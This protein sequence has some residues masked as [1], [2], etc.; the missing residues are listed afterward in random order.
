MHSN[1]ELSS[2]RTYSSPDGTST[3]PG[4][5]AAAA[6]LSLIARRL[7]ANAASG[8]HPSLRPG[9]AREFNQ[10]RAYQPGDESRQ[11]D[12]KLYARSDRFFLR[13]GEMDSRVS[14]AIV[15]DATGSM[16]HRG[17]QGR[18]P[19]KLDCA[20]AVAAALAF[21]AENQGD[22]VSL[23]VV[24]N[25][26]VSSF[27]A[28]GLRQPFRA[29]V[30]RLIRQESQGGWPTDP[31]RLTHA[32]RRSETEGT[33]TGPGTSTRITVILTDGHE[34]HG[35]I[36]AAFAALRTRRHEVLVLQFVAPD[37][38][39]FPYRGPVRFEDWETGESLDAD[40]TMIREH[41]LAARQKTHR[42]WAKAGGDDGYEYLVLMTDEPL[43]RGLRAFLHRRMRR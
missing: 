21:V 26:D 3:G 4:L 36:R 12:W 20:R 43:E 22:P 10:Y 8:L 35:E 5:L 42:A 30:H 13:E 9:R 16:Q 18:A 40:A 11:I 31:I 34:H 41:Y 38:R 32:L 2:E 17:T 39:E 6:E 15:L 7:A 25:G 14:V 33:S 28:A 19:T 27:S 1:H 23:H 24:A 29:I 37:E